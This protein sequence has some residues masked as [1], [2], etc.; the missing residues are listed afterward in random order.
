[1]GKEIHKGD[2]AVTN[3][4]QKITLAVICIRKSRACCTWRGMGLRKI[5]QDLAFGS[6]QMQM[7]LL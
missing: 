2:D 7:K 5:L 3:Y 4:L 1:M 6:E